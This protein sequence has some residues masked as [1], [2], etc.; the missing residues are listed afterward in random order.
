MTKNHPTKTFLQ[1]A[2]ALDDEALSA[3][4]GGAGAGSDDDPMANG[5]CKECGHVLTKT[6]NG[7]S[8]SGCGALYD[9]H[10]R[11]ISS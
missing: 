1:G 4:V 10:K 5:R 8:C 3:T 2:A 11:R 7:Y 6:A 9:A